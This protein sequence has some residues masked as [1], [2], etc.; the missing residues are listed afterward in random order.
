MSGE[1]GL[2]RATCSHCLQTRFCQDGWCNQPV[3]SDCLQPHFEG[4]VYCREARFAVKPA[5]VQ[6]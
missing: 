2:A 6:R 5:K 4:C 1:T 3:C